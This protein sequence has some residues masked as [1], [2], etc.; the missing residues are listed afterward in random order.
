MIHDCGVN[1]VILGHSERRHVFGES[2]E[3]ILDDFYAPTRQL[4]FSL[5]EDNGQKVNQ[6]ILCCGSSS[7]RRQPTL[8]RTVSAW[9][10][11][12]ARS[13]TRERAASQRRS[14]LLRPSSSQVRDSW[15]CDCRL[16][17][18]TL[19][20][21]FQGRFVRATVWKSCEI[22]I[23]VLS[24]VSLSDNV[25]D[26]SKVVL[27]YEPVWAIG[28]GKT[29]SPQQVNIRNH[30]I[31]S[32]CLSVSYITRHNSS[33]SCDISGP[34]GSWETEGMAE[35]QRV[36]GRCQ[37]CEDHLRRS[38]TMKIITFSFWFLTS[39]SCLTCL[40][41]S[42]LRLCDWCYLQRAGLPEGR[43]RFPRRWSFPEARVHRNHQC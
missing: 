42:P 23:Q 2:D 29:A 1:W 43:W 4:L 25:K 6:C 13:W 20:G 10:P 24:H 39:L 26:W 21:I 28:T 12:L 7:A 3:V 31:V 37:L 14:S 19:S 33:V 16:E 40:C 32:D 15:Q 34:G 38:A 22:R 27:A 17:H 5:Y 36:W 11:A 30:C 18:W 35:D 8:W 41:S 9:S